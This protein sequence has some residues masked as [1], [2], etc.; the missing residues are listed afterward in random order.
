[1]DEYRKE[2][3]EA[4]EKAKEYCVKGGCEDVIPRLNLRI[5][6]LKDNSNFFD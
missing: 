2:Q 6:W 3:I 4:L 5:H 1:M